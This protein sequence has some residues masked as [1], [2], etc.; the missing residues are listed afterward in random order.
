MPVAT[1]PIAGAR[2][3]AY[4]LPCY[5]RLDHRHL[6]DHVRDSPTDPAWL[7]EKHGDGRNKLE[8]DFVIPLASPFLRA[9]LSV[10]ALYQ[11]RF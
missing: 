8:S 10:S 11:D 2:H 5:P 7:L 6:G 4:R 1:V 3:T 9:Y